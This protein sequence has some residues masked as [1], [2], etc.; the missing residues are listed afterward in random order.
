MADQK[1]ES[2]EPASQRRRVNFLGAR[3]VSLPWKPEMKS[4]DTNSEV[5]PG[6]APE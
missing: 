5:E 1:G 3:V 6:L 2:V 4:C